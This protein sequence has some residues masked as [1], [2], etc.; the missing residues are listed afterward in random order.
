LSIESRR[1][2]RAVIPTEQHDDVELNISVNIEAGE[3][4]RPFPY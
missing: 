1:L 3:G 4:S 2:L